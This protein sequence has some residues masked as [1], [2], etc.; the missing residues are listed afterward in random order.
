MPVRKRHLYVQRPDGRVF[1]RSYRAEP[2]PDTTWLASIDERLELAHARQDQ[3]LA[4]A[5]T[6]EMLQRG[7]PARR[8]AVLDTAAALWGIQWASRDPRELIDQL[9]AYL[10]AEAEAGR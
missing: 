4:R 10:E 6:R 3:T 8:D 9:I 5:L 2:E 7:A 1:H